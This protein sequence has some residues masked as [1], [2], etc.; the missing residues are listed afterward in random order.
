MDF[1]RCKFLDYNSHPITALAFSHASVTSDKYAPKTLRL[2]VGRANGDIEIWNPRSSWVHEITLKGGRN[3]S[4][5]G[6]AWTQSGADLRLFSIGGSTV[7]T[8]WDLQTGLP[9]DH[10]D[11][12][13]GIVWSIA[14]SPDGTKIAA[15]CDD[16]SVV[17]VDVEGG[18]G[19][20]EH[21]RILQR[22]KSRVLSI[23]WRGNTQVVGGCADGRI[24]VWT[25]VAAGEVGELN[26]ATSEGVVGRIIGTMRV[27]KAQGEET[28]VWSV[29]VL[30]N[31]KTIVSGDSTGS[32]K[33]WDAAH[34]SLLQSFKVHEADVLCLASNEAA[35]T[36]FSA[37]VDHK[38]VRYSVVDNKLRRWAN[39]SS[40]LLHAHDIRA[41]VSYESKNANYLISGG[42][43]RSIV[44][45]S[46]DNFIDG[47][48]RKIPVSPPRHHVHSV[49]DRQL[50]ALCGDNQVKIWAL[51]KFHSSSEAIPEGKNKRVVASLALNNDE[52]I[53][54]AALS[55]DAKYLAVATNAET[56]LF[57][58]LPSKQG[59]GFKAKKIASPALAGQGCSILG[60]DPSSQHLVLV[61]AENEIF[62]YSIG[63]QDKLRELPYTGDSAE[64]KGELKQ[65][66]PY[67]DNINNLAFSA[68]GKY[69]A[70]STISGYVVVYDWPNQSIHWSLPR[71]PSIPSVLKFCP[72]NDSLIVV[73]TQMKVLQFSVASQALSDWSRRNSGILPPEFN[74]LVDKCSGIS[75]DEEAPDRAWMWG[76]S[77][78]ANFDMSADIPVFRIPKRKRNGLSVE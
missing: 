19:V 34:F 67:L 71:I 44:I 18:R 30:G 4:I 65:A 63:H 5:E 1:R 43:E 49:G 40:R 14:P 73:T 54:H 36:V 17:I 11:C 23:A 41:L 55:V 62:I 27:D 60:F 42:V 69:F 45:N 33:F 77:W 75:I 52:N 57:L 58:L 6:L 16:G 37:G 21:G 7:V 70:L 76:A 68:D 78:L 31:G 15:G 13:A 29:V 32:V 24:R 9:L 48:F 3:R 72:D 26:G 10:C 25:A 50:V 22:H 2:A 12:N 38:I 20:M 47:V 35:D 56:K 61:T 28:L 74:N 66:L 53:T 51:E 39:M 59:F 46:V 64:G 8:E